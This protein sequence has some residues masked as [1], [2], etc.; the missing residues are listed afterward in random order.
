MAGGVLLL[1]A[2]FFVFSWGDAALWYRDST[3]STPVRV[4]STQAP[5]DEYAFYLESAAGEAPG[6]LVQILPVEQARQLAGKQVTLGAWM[7]SSRPVDVRSPE[8]FVYAKGKGYR[9]PV[10]LTTQPQFF[11]FTTRLGRDTVRS[12]VILEPTRSVQDAPLE[13]YFDGL[14]LAEGAFP[15]DQAP[16]F[17]SPA[18]QSGIWGG[19]KFS[20]LLRNASAEVSGPIVQPWVDGLGERF[21]PGTGFESLSLTLYSV[22]DRPAAGWYYLNTFKNLGRTFWAVFGWNGVYLSGTN[23]YRPLAWITWIGLAGAV[24]AAWRYRTRLSWGGVFFFAVALLLVWVFAMLRGSNYIFLRT[25]FYPAARYVY[26]AVIPA[27]LA[28]VGG[29]VTLLDLT[30]GRWLH[31]ENSKPKWLI[32]LPLIGFFFGLNVYSLISMTQHWQAV[33]V[34]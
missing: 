24:L 34:L 25:G 11:A 12:W 22:L 10:S 31:K 16:I 32:Y 20:N 7:W 19:T 17:E 9:R 4:A 23:P 26:P 5:L 1:A 30:L 14:V 15:V 2:V 33:G 27:M 6:R 13:I 8:I 21:L 18:A 29:W 28:F 3:Q